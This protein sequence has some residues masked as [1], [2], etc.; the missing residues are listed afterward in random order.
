MTTI[1]KICCI[2][3]GYVGGPTCSV[4]A[5]KCPD[6]QVTVVDLSQS[7]IDAW[8]SDQLPIFEPGLQ[9][10]VENCRGRNLFFSTDVDKAIKEADLIFICVNT[11]TKT[12]GVGKGRAADLKYIESAARKI[13]DVATGTKMVV[14]KSTVPVRAAE[15]I[16]RILAANTREDM[17]IQVMSNPEFL[18]EGTAVKDL[19]NPDRVLIG[20]EETE[21]GH[22][23]VQALTDV[24]A[25]WVPREKILTTN[26]W[27]SELSKLAAN[28]FLAQRISSINSISAVCEATGANVSEVAHAIGMDSRIGNKFLKAS[29]GFGGSCFQKDVL[30]LVYLCEALNLPEVAA[31]WQEVIN[32][33]DYQRRRFTNRIIECLFNTVTGKKIAILGFAFKKDTG[34]TRESSSIYVCKYLMDEGAHLHIYD[35]QVKKEQILYDLKQPIISDDPDR[36]EKLVTIETDPYKALEGTHAL[37]VCTEWDEFVAYDYERIYSSMLKPAF[38]FDGR[39]ILD[40]AALQEMGFQVEVIGKKIKKPFSNGNLNGNER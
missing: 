15:S 33:N 16:S 5:Y 37:V 35:P 34:D 2:G 21:E 40:H 13:A 1:R 38:V 30:N 24:Y 25:H 22:K 18:A 36:V 23:A 14:E 19:L 26:T 20:G 32:M 12:F 10:L 17:N 8:N 11:P 31:Y 29:V 6:I 3:A 27:S 9:D 7:R 39:M 4:I 28:A